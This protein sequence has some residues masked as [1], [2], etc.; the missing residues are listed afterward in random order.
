[1]HPYLRRRAGQEAVDYPDERIRGGAGKDAGGADLPGTGDAA[2]RRGGRVHAGRGRSAAAGHG[3]LAAPRRHGSLSP[4][5]RQRHAR[6]R[7]LGT[8]SPTASFARSRASANTA[9]PNRTPPRSPCWSTSPPGSSIYYP[10]A[11]AAALLNSQPMGFYAPAQLVADARKHGVASAA[12]DVNFSQWDCTLEETTVGSCPLSVASCQNR[13]LATDNGQLGVAAKHYALRLGFRLIGGFSRRHADQVIAQRGTTKF[14]SFEDFAVRTNLHRS[15]LVRL[16]Q[17]SA[18][19]S[20]ELKRRQA[21]WLAMTASEPMPL[22]DSM[23]EEVPV[24]LPAMSQLQ[25]VLADYRAKGMTLREHPVHFL[26][27]FSISSAAPGPAISVH[28]QPIARSRW[29]AWC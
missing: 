17:A 10:A 29:P 6:Q 9:F 28:S 16:A 1:M 23:E 26:R 2:R 18:F 8:S 12:V 15:V 25:E 19:E 14:T 21:L 13:Q 7:L 4:E 20:M 3:G 27:P 5:A 11:F 24:T 22:F